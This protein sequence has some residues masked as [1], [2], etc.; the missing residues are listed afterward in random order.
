MGSRQVDIQACKELQHRYSLAFV[1][2]MELK[3]LRIPK[4]S[5]VAAQNHGEVCVIA[6]GSIVV[7][8]VS[9]CHMTH[10]PAWSR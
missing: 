7:R 6:S 1:G 2:F 5:F 9:A 4:P 8:T 10:R 3:A